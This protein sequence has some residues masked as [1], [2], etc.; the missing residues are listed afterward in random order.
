MHGIG[1]R[2]RYAQRKR[3]GTDQKRRFRTEYP[4]SRTRLYGTV[5]PRESNFT[6]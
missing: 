1:L 6:T 4:L 3:M 2:A 5:L